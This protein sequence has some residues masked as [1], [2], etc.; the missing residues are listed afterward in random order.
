MDILLFDKDGN[1]KWSA[2]DWLIQENGTI[3]GLYA[4]ATDVVIL[5]GSGTVTNAAAGSFQLFLTGSRLNIVFH[6]A[7]SNGRWDSGEDIVA[8]V[9]RN[10]VFNA[11]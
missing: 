9:V 2:G 5:Q 10:R 7:N 6:D 4:T 3:D 8:D 11:P 1:K